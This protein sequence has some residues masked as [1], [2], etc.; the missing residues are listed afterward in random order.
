MRPWRRTYG[1]RRWMSGEKSYRQGRQRGGEGRGWAGEKRDKPRPTHPDFLETENWIVACGSRPISTR[2]CTESLIHVT[3]VRI[4]DPA[5]SYSSLLIS[6]T[7]SRPSVTH[8]ASRPPPNGERTERTPPQKGGDKPL[9]RGKPNSEKHR[10]ER[11]SSQEICEGSVSRFHRWKS[12]NQQ[13]ACQT[14]RINERE[15][16][17]TRH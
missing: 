7:V 3:D 6:A 14:I 16:R 8:L 9:V 1:T 13:P 15:P 17:K 10:P 12:L 4:V 2:E 11:L 5:F